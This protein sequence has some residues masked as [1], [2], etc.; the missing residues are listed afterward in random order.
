MNEQHCSPRIGM[1]MRPVTREGTA[2]DRRAV[3]KGRDAAGR[4]ILD[5]YDPLTDGCRHKAADSADWEPEG[6]E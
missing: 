1:R 5:V 6:A 3:V 4:L 2:Q